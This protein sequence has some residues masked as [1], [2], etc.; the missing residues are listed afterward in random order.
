M[1]GHLGPVIG[2]VGGSGGVGASAFAAVLAGVAGPSVLV[3]VDVGGGGIDV[4]LGVESAP[5]ARWSGLRLAGGRLEPSALV[6]GL[7]RWGR[8]AVLAADCPELDADAVSQVL[9]TAA[10]AGPVIVD[11]PRGSCAERAAALL[12][13]E[14]VVVLARADVSGLVAAHAVAGALPE[15]PI[16]VV[17]RR[18][19]VGPGDAA[20]L[21]GAPL[22]GV[23]PGLRAAIPALDPRRLPRSAARVA[24]GVLDGLRGWPTG[25]HALARR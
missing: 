20:E 24:G 25:R 21:V 5:G 18:G 23:L 8:C 13:C 6:D 15:L 17:V 19:D 2:V 1:D 16:G 11:L 14:L 3:D 4:T 12:H 10:R 7:P 9:R 22:L